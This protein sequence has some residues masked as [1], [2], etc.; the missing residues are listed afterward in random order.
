MEI[1]DKRSGMHTVAGKI[2]R[3]SSSNKSFDGELFYERIN[4]GIQDGL[5]WQRN[6][7]FAA[8][9]KIFIQNVDKSGG[10]DSLSKSSTK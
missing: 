4:N 3:P 1:L 5:T 8:T 2:P 6:K 9:S 10:G 7:H